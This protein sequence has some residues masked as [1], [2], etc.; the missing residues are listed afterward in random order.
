MSSVFCHTQGTFKDFDFIILCE[1]IFPHLAQQLP[2]V[3]FFQICPFLITGLEGI[4]R[5]SIDPAELYAVLE[6]LLDDI[7]VTIDRE[8]GVAAL[9]PLFLQENESQRCEIIDR[10]VS[11]VPDQHRYGSFVM[12]ESLGLPAV[13]DIVTLPPFEKPHR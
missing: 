3:L 13:L 6:R 12:T 4:I 9:N 5:S 10:L 8:P 1:F 2:L 11:V 7:N